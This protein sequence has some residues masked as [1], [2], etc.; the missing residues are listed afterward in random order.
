MGL[1]WAYPPDGPPVEIPR[2]DPLAMPNAASYTR[3]DAWSRPNSAQ[4]WLIPDHAWP[5]SAGVGRQHLP[6]GQIRPNI[7]LAD[8]WVGA[9]PSWSTP[10]SAAPADA[11]PASRPLCLNNRRGRRAAG[12]LASRPRRRNRRGGRGRG[13]AA[14]ASPSAAPGRRGA[15]AGRLQ[16]GN[17]QATSATQPAE[18]IRVRAGADP[19][20][21]ISFSRQGRS[22]TKARSPKE[23]SARLPRCIP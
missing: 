21:R 15:T 9:A 12:L 11:G 16:G 23:G 19:M 22:G 3:R 4:N 14:A 17:A 10:H 1:A 20:K 5:M 6:V 7:A 2:A 18:R 8:A 13:P